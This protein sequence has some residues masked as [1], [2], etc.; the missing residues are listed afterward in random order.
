MRSVVEA[1]L[2]AERA[3]DASGCVAMCA[4]DIEQDVVGALG[5]PVYGRDAARRFYDE[6]ARNTRTETAD[7]IRSYFGRSDFGDDFCVLEQLWTGTVPGTL[8]GI[9][10]NGRRIDVRRLQLWEFREGR[11]SRETIWLDR[12]GILAQ[13][14][15]PSAV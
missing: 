15:A 11:V 12:D 1:R 5:G 2:A 8:A 9:S 6:L 7:T 13:L 3:G 4:D 10:G 14:G